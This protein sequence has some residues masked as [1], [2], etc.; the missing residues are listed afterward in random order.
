MKKTTF[1]LLAYL[2]LLFT[3]NAQSNC[4]PDTLHTNTIV[5]DYLADSSIDIGPWDDKEVILYDT[6]F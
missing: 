1:F 4:E 6:L 3:T 5:I 2:C